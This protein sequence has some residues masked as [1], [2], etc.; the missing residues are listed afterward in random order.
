MQQRLNLME[1]S[2]NRLLTDACAAALRAFFSAAK[3]GR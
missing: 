1:R 3:P 2:N